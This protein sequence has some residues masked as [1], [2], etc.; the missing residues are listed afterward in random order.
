MKLVVDYSQPFSLLDW[1]LIEHPTRTDTV[2]ID[3]DDIEAITTLK[4]DEDYVQ[5]EENLT[6]I[7]ATGKTL[8]DARV[9]EELLKHPEAIPEKW[10]Q[11]TNGYITDIFFPGTVLMDP[12]GYRC[13]L[14]LYWDDG[15]WHWSDGWLERD[16]RA[17]NLS[18]V[19]ASSA[20][21]PLDSE[22]KPSDTLN[23]DGLEIEIEGMRY[24]LKKL[25]G[26]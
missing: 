16:W 11:E 20:L 6:R 21:S 14:C 9:L 23:L 13:V 2:T 22:S 10:K 12:D 24:K 17:S 8:L 26:K 5:G 18:A 1:K 3:T 15:G 4:D 7:K 25:D 19:L